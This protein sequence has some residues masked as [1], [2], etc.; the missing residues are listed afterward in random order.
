[1]PA[2]ILHPALSFEDRNAPGGVYS[3]CF[4]NF[5]RHP[6]SLSQLDFITDF[7]GETRP[8]PPDRFVTDFYRP[9]NYDQ[10]LVVAAFG[11]VLDDY[12][13]TGFGAKGGSALKRSQVKYFTLC[14]PF[15]SC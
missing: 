13:G 6:D 15:G 2:A 3:Q 8:W 10:N 5:T 1:M 7:H 14:H 9:G 4:D 11:E 12:E